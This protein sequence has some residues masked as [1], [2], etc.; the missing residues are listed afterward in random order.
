M[1]NPVLESG[2]ASR[3]LP[4]SSLL[5]EA[6]VITTRRLSASERQRL[7]ADSIRSKAYNEG[8]DGGYA[9]G[10]HLG[11]AAG[12]AAGFQAAE[13]EAAE[14]R[15]VEL[16]KLTSNLGH[17]EEL[18]V[19]GVHNWFKFAEVEVEKLVV[20]IAR[21]VLRQE[22]ALSRESV[23]AIVVSALKEVTLSR[24]ARIRVNPLDVDALNESKDELI[25]CCSSLRALEIVDDPSILGGCVIE[26]DGGRVDVSTESQLSRLESA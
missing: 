13:A 25:A 15:R 10:K 26:T 11:M 24:S 3:A 12:Q 19:E 23:R 22:L 7:E 20:D 6:N 2:E 9:A 17:L 14:I 1:F 21:E 4:F 18:V 16:E 8:F 5:Q